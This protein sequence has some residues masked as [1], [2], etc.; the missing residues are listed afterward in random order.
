M[1]T[2]IAA[3]LSGIMIDGLVDMGPS[4][5]NH[6]LWTRCRSVCHLLLLHW[7]DLYSSL[8]H[9]QIRRR[10]PSIDWDSPVQNRR[11]CRIRALAERHC[12]HL[13]EGVDLVGLKLPVSLPDPPCS[14]PHRSCV[15]A[16]GL[17]QWHECSAA[18]TDSPGHD[19]VL[20]ILT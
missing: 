10:I 2:E 14:A 1:P 7:I 5:V 12:A 20:H 6:A 17:R 9:V 3:V 15:L 13:V 18:N 8:M 11:V 19:C 4:P 16:P